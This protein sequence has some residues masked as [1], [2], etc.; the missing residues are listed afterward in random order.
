MNK[1]YAVLLTFHA[2]IYCKNAYLL[3]PT[4]FLIFTRNPN[5]N[6]YII[7]SKICFEQFFCRQVAEALIYNFDLAKWIARQRRTKRRSIFQTI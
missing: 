4:K 1:L 7:L 5:N 2:C 3:K 6:N